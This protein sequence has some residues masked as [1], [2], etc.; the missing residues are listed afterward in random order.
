MFWS[1][2]KSPEPLKQSN[3]IVDTSIKLS[4]KEI[5]I[6]HAYELSQALI[7]LLPWLSTD[8]RIA[9]H[10]IYIP[11]TGNGWQ[12]PAAD[13]QA[14]IPISRRTRLKIR[15]PKEYLTRLEQINGQQ[16]QLGGE[17]MTFG[18]V[19]S[20]VLPATSTLISRYTYIQ[21][22]SEDEQDFL[23]RAYDL[24][25]SRGLKISKMLCG[26]SVYLQRK[27][28]KLLTRSLMLAEMS[29][30]DSIALQEMGI[31]ENSLMGCGIFIPQK[32]I[33]AVNDN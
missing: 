19:T 18:E 5:P 7:E 16:I 15:L 6:D 29:P 33:K 3:D 10:Q 13:I 8:N 32:G 23:N 30:L 26:K 12:R 17:K 31:G 11:A 21:D 20:S 27:K 28:E 9:I 22:A 14:K 4:C 1:E 25:S 24:L 2:E